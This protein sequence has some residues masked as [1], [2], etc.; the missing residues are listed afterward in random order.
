MT[1]VWVVFKCIVF[2]ENTNLIKNRHILCYYFKKVTIEGEKMKT[3]YKR[4]KRCSVK[5]RKQK[6]KYYQRGYRARTKKWN[7]KK[8]IF[9]ILGCVVLIA[10]SAL[11]IVSLASDKGTSSTQ[12]IQNKE[13]I[14]DLKIDVAETKDDLAELSGKFDH[15]MYQN[16]E[17]MLEMKQAIN[18]AARD[19]SVHVTLSNVGIADTQTDTSSASQA[20]QDMAVSSGSEEKNMPHSGE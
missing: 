12:L 13:D 8:K 20:E 5:V 15:F 16:L 11:A 14:A 7:A 3:K 1:K 9:L 6:S 2:F 19:E 4:K 18:Q 10:V 17:L